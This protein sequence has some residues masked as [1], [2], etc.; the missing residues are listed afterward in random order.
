[1]SVIAKRC[2]QKISVTQFFERYGIEKHDWWVT[3]RLK[4]DWRIHSCNLLVE[5]NWLLSDDLW[6]PTKLNQPLIILKLQDYLYTFPNI[7]THDWSQLSQNKFRCFRAQNK[8]L[9]TF[10]GGNKTVIFLIRRKSGQKSKKFLLAPSLSDMPKSFGFFFLPPPITS[11]AHVHICW[12]LSDEKEV[13]SLGA[14][15]NKIMHW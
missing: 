5:E 10:W 2:E 1:M 12:Y 9:T 14:E 11:R 3:H 6:S 4:P 15:L 8:V 13:K 7:Y